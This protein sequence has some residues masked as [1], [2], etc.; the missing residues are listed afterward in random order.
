M[1]P[2]PI[3]AEQPAAHTGDLPDRADVVVIGGGVIGVSAALFL[4]RAG[5]SVVLV[6][7]GRIAGEQSSRNWGWIRVQGRDPAEIPI[8]QEAQALWP[9]L[10]AQVDTDIGLTQGGVAYLARDAAEMARFADWLRLAEPYG[11]SSQLLDGDGAARLLPEAAQ[12]WP[13]ALWTPTDM[14]A[15]PFVTVPALARLAAKA[16]AVIREDCAAR[17]LDL[18]G[19]R[20]AGV[21]TEHGRI[22]AG[23]V[24]LAGGAWSSLFLRRHGISI[25]QL[26]VRATAMRTAALG[27]VFQGGAVDHRMAF[28]RRVDGGYTLAPE[29]FHELYIGPDAFRAFARYLRQMFKDPFGTALRPVA[30]RGYPDG[31]ATP[32][33]WRADGPSPFERMRVLNP[34]PNMA[35]VR[36]TARAFGETFPELGPVEIE[37]AWAGMIDTLPDVVPVVDHAAQIPGLTIATGMCGHGFG[38]GPAF[39]RIVADMVQGKPP[40]HDLA[41]F[42]LAR[43]SDGSPLEL[44][45]NL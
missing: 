42:R 11:V 22:R 21:I 25:P 12:A 19:G 13:G 24:V 2:F 35:K 16:G 15:E 29:G 27:E 43:F 32:R 23:A 20:V 8:A 36:E 41:R 6:E 28:R 33:R 10:A 38:I 7:K 18:E 3:S 14:R 30:P 39:G 40:G 17:L 31:W 1:T 4:A 44:G 45:P 37:S 9:Q 34:A 5:V 26:S